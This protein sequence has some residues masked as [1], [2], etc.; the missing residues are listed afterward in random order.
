MAATTLINDPI[1]YAPVTRSYRRWLAASMVLLLHLMVLGG[2]AVLQ[3]PSPPPSPTRQVLD[4]V[5]V[6]EPSETVRHARALAEANQQGAGAAGS[7]GAVLRQVSE[8]QTAAGLRGAAVWRPEFEATPAG[9]VALSSAAA[10]G[11]FGDPGTETYMTPTRGFVV[12]ESERG[13]AERRS[14]DADGP[15]RTAAMAQAGARYEA[16]VVSL[17]EAVGSF[18]GQSEGRVKVLVEIGSDGQLLRAEVLQSS[19]KPELDRLSLET[20]H[21]AA[22][23]PAF[24]QSMSDMSSYTIQRIFD[25]G[26]T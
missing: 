12:S 19:D 22:P 14:G 9:D 21:D 3:S 25:F 13:R 2:T 23:Y 17:I 7:D 10:P 1:R 4:V 6:T 8:A 24:D 26:K 11:G 15:A 16:Q 5:L 18:R 20:V